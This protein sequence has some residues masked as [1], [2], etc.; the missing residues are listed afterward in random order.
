M[1]AREFEV[2]LMGPSY[3]VRLDAHGVVAERG[4]WKRSAPLDRLMYLYVH[5]ANSTMQELILAHGP[6]A[7]HL[8][9]IRIVANADDPGLQALVP[10]LLEACPKLEDLR[11][12]P[13]KEALAKMG[14][15]NMGR[16]V[17]IALIPIFTLLA[18]LVMAP[19]FVHGFDAR[20]DT[21]ALDDLVSDSYARE[22]YNVT[23]TN[24]RLLHDKAIEK[25]STRDGKTTTSYLMPMVSPTWHPGDPVLVVWAT[26]ALTNEQWNALDPE[27]GITGVVRDA[28]W[29]GGLG[30]NERDFFIDRLGLNVSDDVLLVELD[31]DTQLEAITAFGI[32]GSV[33]VLMSVVAVVVI[34]RHG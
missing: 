22:S 23:I 27:A 1:E 10:A 31:A 6:S 34:R 32:T 29:E 25:T 18:A 11:G 7:D 20:H 30:S 4:L 24:G 5:A 33:F 8:S 26:P 2:R 12:T 3:R 16:I 28:L 15:A 9:V 14:A 13:R 21:V 17:P 19:M